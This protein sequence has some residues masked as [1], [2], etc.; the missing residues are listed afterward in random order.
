MG[1]LDVPNETVFVMEMTPIKFGIGA[2]AE[3]AYD[4]K[5][6]GIQ[7]ALIVTD[8]GLMQLGLPERVRRL[9]T[10]A[11]LQADIYDD[12]HVEPTDRSF[13]EI[14]RFIEGRNYD[15]MIAIG[16]GS[17]IDTAKW[18]RLYATYPAPLMDYVNK[19][20]GKG[21]PVPGPLKPLIAIPTT[22]GTG[23]E[24]TAVAILDILALK[25]KTGISHPFLRPT[26]AII[27]P[28]NTV[29][30]P[31]MATAYPGFDV[32]T[33]ALESYTSRP[34]QAR[35]RHKPEERPVYVGS[36]P[37]SDLWCEK[38]LEYL[39]HYLRRAVL[40]GMD[41]EARTY[42]ALAATYAGIGFGNAGVHIPHALAY[43]I[44]G[45]VKRFSP[46]DYPHE[47]PLIP[48]GLSVIV[49]APA[50]FRWTYPADPERHLRAA[51]L[52]GAQVSGLNEA[53]R[54][55]I[56]PQTLLTLMRDTGVP[57]NLGALGY[58]GEEVPALVEG[59]LKQ[60]RLLVNSPRAVG[61]EELRQLIEQSFEAAP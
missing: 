55:E 38:A 19:P 51:Q 44:A 34:Y 40:N 26:F 54:R 60:Q 46:P 7:R 45:M 28:L 18:A 20:I 25:V 10:E 52:L 39:G 4:A 29:T 31:P 61:A 49:T 32:L 23:S 3:V 53:Q 22:A 37:I 8:R 56:L 33:H 2:T 50:T 27:D 57:S 12:V 35:P 17:S 15:G 47:E 24:T 42:L 5:R 16:G 58:T 41:V 11:G 36:N 48:H 21:Q 1:C 14:A 6:L 30:L 9:L 13:E 59:A 43:P